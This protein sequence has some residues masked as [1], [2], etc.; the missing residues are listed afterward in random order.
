MNKLKEFLNSYIVEFDWKDIAIF[1]LCLAAFGVMIGISLPR[2]NKRSIL[3]I[4]GAVF[5]VTTI[6]ILCRLL[7]MEC[8]FCKDED[9]FLDWDDDEDEEGFVMKI[10]SED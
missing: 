5:A 6:V 8:P 1:K 3:A 4:S 7:G 9:E 2:E 10:T